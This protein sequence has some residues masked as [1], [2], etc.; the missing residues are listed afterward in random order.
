MGLS[1]LQLPNVGYLAGVFLTWS[2]SPYGAKWFATLSTN[3][4]LFSS[5]WASRNPLTG[6]SGLQQEERRYRAR[7]VLEGVAIPLRG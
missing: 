3:T 7:T 5:R 6:L 4:P 2:Q 1:G